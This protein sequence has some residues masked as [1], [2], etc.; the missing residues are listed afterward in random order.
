MGK[1]LRT[2][3][4]VALLLVVTLCALGA[5]ACGDDELRKA[6]VASDR[7][8][9]SIE[10][11]IE[12]EDTF[13]KA[14]KIAP[15]EDLRISK[16]LLGV[17]RLVK[18]YNDQVKAYAARLKAGGER[19]NAVEIGFRALLGEIKERLKNRVADGTF[20]VKNPDSQKAINSGLDTLAEIIETILD[21]LPSPRDQPGQ[22]I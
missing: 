10:A 6:A 11:T 12:V 13:V 21:S 4:S 5:K 7:L 19:D 2:G 8:A 9:K 15:E 20:K 14:G 17:N 3:L 18:D 22:R 1:L 16:E